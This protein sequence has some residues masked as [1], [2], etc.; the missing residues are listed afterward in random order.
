MMRTLPSQPLRRAFCCPKARLI[1]TETSRPRP[2]RETRIPGLAP[3]KRV[4]KSAGLSEGTKREPNT[5]DRANL[6]GFA[7]AAHR[8]KR[9]DKAILSFGLPRITRLN[10][11][12]W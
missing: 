6:K 7:M 4:P 5:D 3:E 10:R 12:W 1:R 11:R 2:E 8:A 9:R